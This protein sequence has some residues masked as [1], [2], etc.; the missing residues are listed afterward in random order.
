MNLPEM[1]RLQSEGSLSVKKTIK[2]YSILMLT[3]QFILGKT[4]SSGASI[5]VAP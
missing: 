4:L 2:V 3:S 1:F 5:H